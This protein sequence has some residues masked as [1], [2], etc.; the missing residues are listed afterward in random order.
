MNSFPISPLSRIAKLPHRSKTAKPHE[1]KALFP[2]AF[3]IF[4][5]SHLNG[6]TG[7]ANLAQGD[8]PGLLSNKHASGLKGRDIR[9][10]KIWDAPPLPPHS[11][12]FAFI[13]G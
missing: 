9:P 8:S 1:R 10:A 13:R 7:R 4:G 2:D 11:R 6:P 3:N 12:L 5:D